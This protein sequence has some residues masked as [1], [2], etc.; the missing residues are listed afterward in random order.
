MQSKTCNYMAQLYIDLTV[1]SLTMLNI[2]KLLLELDYSMHQISVAKHISKNLCLTCCALECQC[3][4][5]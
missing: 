2:I 3:L 5:V 4:T 1:W